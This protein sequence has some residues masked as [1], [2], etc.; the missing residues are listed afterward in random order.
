MRTSIVSGN[1]ITNIHCDAFSEHPPKEV[2]IGPY[3][4][5]AILETYGSVS[6]HE[7]LALF[8]SSGYLEIAVRNGNA[9]DQLDLKKGYV[10]EVTR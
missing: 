5:D 7:P 1:C 2:H 3:V 4:F 10:I 8:G 9:A 6:K